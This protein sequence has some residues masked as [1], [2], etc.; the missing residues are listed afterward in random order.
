M[1]G[2]YFSVLALPALFISAIA[3]PSTAPET[4]LIE[5]RQNSSA[6]AS[7]YTIVSDLYTEIQQYT[8]AISRSKSTLGFNTES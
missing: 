5:K 6:E 2:S 1:K 3:A 4:S 8:G 7:A